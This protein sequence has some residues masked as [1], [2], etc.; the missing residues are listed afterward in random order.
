MGNL[1][2]KSRISLVVAVVLITYLSI[3]PMDHAVSD[4]LNDKANHFIAFYVL[5]F[6]AD[7]SFPETRFDWRK[8][9]YI[10]GYGVAIEVIQFYLPNRMFSLFDVLADGAGILI[11]AL[12]I[13]W[14]KK[15]AVLHPRWDAYDASG[16]S[17][18]A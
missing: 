6:L 13:P 15:L 14:L 3:T 7:F 12:S 16:K 11:F 2:I 9:M 4:S 5:S 1:T 8:V 18:R 10:L 17:R